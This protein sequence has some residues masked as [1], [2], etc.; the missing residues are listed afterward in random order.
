MIISLTQNQPLS[1]RI[2]LVRV[3]KEL[4]FMIENLQLKA[5][6][7]LTGFRH[8]FNLFLLSFIQRKYLISIRSMCFCYLTIIDYLHENLGKKV[9]SRKRYVESWIQTSNV[10]RKNLESDKG[11]LASRLEYS[12]HNH[13]KRKQKNSIPA[14]KPKPIS[15]I[16]LQFSLQK[17]NNPDDLE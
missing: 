13:R 5:I 4:L 16:Q 7:F 15:A 12:S 1:V 17:N 11:D 2:F 14:M 3:S 8:L 9:Q 6:S 10:K